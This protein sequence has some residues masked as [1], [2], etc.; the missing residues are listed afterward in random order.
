MFHAASG[1]LDGDAEDYLRNDIRR[2]PDPAYS[3][4]A[5]EALAE[6]YLPMYRVLDALDCLKQWLELRP[7]EV[8]ALALRGD[9]YWQIGALAR[10]ADDYQ[11]VVDLD[12][13][14]DWPANGWRWA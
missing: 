3:A 2:N 7:D 9:L 14:G 4:P 8:Q 11:R 10:S 12:P 5:R 6:G 1:D 13:G